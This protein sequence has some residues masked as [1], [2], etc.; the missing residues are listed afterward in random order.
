MYEI[1]DSF[2][3]KWVSELCRSDVIII[4]ATSLRWKHIDSDEIDMLGADSLS[5]DKVLRKL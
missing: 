3:G 1:P 4:T 2:H 5:P